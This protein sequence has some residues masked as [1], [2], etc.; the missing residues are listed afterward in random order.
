[1]SHAL[2]QQCFTWTTHRRSSTRPKN[3]RRATSQTRTHHALHVSA[4]IALA[5]PKRGIKHGA[6]TGAKS[7][8]EWTG[9]DGNFS[10]GGVFRI[11]KPPLERPFSHPLPG[12]TDGRQSGGIRV[13][14]QRPARP[15]GR[16]HGTSSRGN[17]VMRKAAGCE[18]VSDDKILRSADEPW[19]EC[20]VQEL[21][22]MLRG[23]LGQWCVRFFFCT[24][25]DAHTL[26]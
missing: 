20:E 16:G 13:P 10:Y 15:R 22:G 9:L 23:G 12:S 17:T 19:W 21:L 2:H 6:N 26:V 24:M 7:G 4:H 25:V 3:A 8:D 1:M 18:G 11:F 14:R 5:Q